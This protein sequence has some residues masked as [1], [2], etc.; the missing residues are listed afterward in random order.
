MGLHG[1]V[2]G[3]RRAEGVFKDPV[4]FSKGLLNVPLSELEVVADIRFLPWPDVGK[5]G[6]G[7]G[8][9]EFLV[10]ERRVRLCGLKD[11]Q[12]S[13]ERL[14]VDVNEFKCILCPAA[15]F[16]DN[17]YDRISDVVDPIDRQDGLV[18]KGRAEI[19]VYPGQGGDIGSSDY[20]N[21]SIQ[22]FSS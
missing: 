4:R 22:G 7:P 2:L 11:I 1:H 10:D 13:R 21:N 14:V 8:R 15:V 3:G 9:S 19:G 18:P 20:R 6:K 16:R 12:D 5:I 17:G